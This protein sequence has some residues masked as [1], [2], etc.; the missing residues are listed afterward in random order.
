MH[1]FVQQRR[2]MIAQQTL[3]LHGLKCAYYSI[4][5]SDNWEFQLLIQIREIMH[6]IH[7]VSGR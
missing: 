7:I 6:G 3:S 2:V 4:V 1:C 5:R